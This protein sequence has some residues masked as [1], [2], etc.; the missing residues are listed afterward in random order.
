M[1]IYTKI[2]IN[3]EGETIHE[4]SYEYNGP[5]AYCGGSKTVVQAPKP[6][7]TELELQREQLKI[8]REQ[9]ELFKVYQAE[10]L[11]DRRMQREEVAKIR[12]HL[13]RTMGLIDDPA[14]GGFRRLTEEERLETMTES[15]RRAYDNLKLI[16]ERQARALKGELPVSPA[17]ERSLTEQEEQIGEQLSRRLG[18]RWRETTPGIQA[19]SAFKERAEALREGARRGEVE[20]GTRLVLPR[21]ELMGGQRSLRDEQFTRFPRRRGLGVPQFGGFAEAFGRAQQPYQYQR[22]LEYQ[23]GVETARARAQRMAG[24]GQLLGTGLTAAATFWSSKK[25][26]KDIKK[27][28]AKDEGKS[29]AM[30]KKAGVYRFRYKDEPKTNKLRIGLLTEKAPDAVITNDRLGIDIGSHLGMLL[31]GMKTL[32]RKVDK[33]EREAA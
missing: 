23:A 20:L 10:Q 32:A 31:A 28:S 21:M 17:L 27:I 18:T 24:F 1:K 22:G 30:I 15:E 16:Q 11:A 8:L 26:K 12:P 9:N 14:T 33:I 29:L 7:A 25:F 3:S 5:I 2:V 13:L 4:E 19:M 6:T